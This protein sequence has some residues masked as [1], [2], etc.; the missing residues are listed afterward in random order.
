VW[1]AGCNDLPIAL[2]HHSQSESLHMATTDTSAVNKWFYKV[3]DVKHGPVTANGLRE[4]II[5]RKVPADA[6]A[7]RHGMEAYAPVHQLDEVFPEGV[8]PGP[9]VYVSEVKSAEGHVSSKKPSLYG[10][11]GVLVLSLLGARLITGRT[12]DPFVYDR[13]SGDLLYEDGK[14]IPAEGLNVTFIPLVPPHDPRTYPRPGFA[15]VDASTGAFESVTSQRPGDGLVRGS[16][17]V[18]IA[19]LNR[20]PLPPDVVPVEYAVFE[21]TPLTIDT[22]TRRLQL[23]VARPKKTAPIQK[24]NPSRPNR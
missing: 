6:L 10:L 14:V 22:S 4:M 15:T 12:S 23:R 9:L 5:R 17:K 2:N 19:G 20:Q 24:P 11:A 1:V 3:G 8:V 21:T 16:H 13:V 18:L 7:W